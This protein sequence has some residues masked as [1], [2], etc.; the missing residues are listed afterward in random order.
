[1]VTLEETRGAVRQAVDRGYRLGQAAC[2]FGIGLPQC[3]IRRRAIRAEVEAH[4]G[5]LSGASRVLG[6]ARST[7]YGA[8]QWEAGTA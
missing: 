5:N 8:L 1:M 3:D 4:A 6:V 7:V 2:G